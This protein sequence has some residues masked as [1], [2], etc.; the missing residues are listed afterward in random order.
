M[1]DIVYEGVLDIGRFIK[2]RGRKGIAA[3]SRGINQIKMRDDN[4]A[5]QEAYRKFGVTESSV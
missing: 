5:T 1:P 3:P 4:K 2:T